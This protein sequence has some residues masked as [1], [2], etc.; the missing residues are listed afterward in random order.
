M[1]KS[2]IESA[3]L[4]LHMINRRLNRPQM[5]YNHVTKTHNTGSIYIQRSVG[6]KGHTVYD[7][8]EVLDEAGAFKTYSENLNAREVIIWLDGMSAGLNSAKS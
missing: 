8:N 2:E 4:Y 1:S 5:A 3:E 6:S 7:I